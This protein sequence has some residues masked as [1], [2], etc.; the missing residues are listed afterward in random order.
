M[1]QQCQ[2]LPVT[3]TEDCYIEASI[4]ATNGQLAEQWIEY[5]SC[6]SEQ[7][8]KLRAIQSLAECRITP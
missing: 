5:K 3:L 6:A 1:V 4:P 2:S 8:V 7:S